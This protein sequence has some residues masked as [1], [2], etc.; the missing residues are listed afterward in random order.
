MASLSP[1]EVSELAI[2]AHEAFLEGQAGEDIR[3][4]FG[5]DHDSFREVLTK[6]FD[7]QATEVRGRPTEHVYVQYVIDQCRNIADLTK[8][9]GKFQTTSSHSAMVSAIRA[10]SDIQDK[11]LERGQ[12][13][14]IIAKEPEKSGALIAGIVIAD[15]SNPQLKQTVVRELANV[16][17][18]M[19]DTGDIDFM[20]IE[21]GPIHRGPSAPLPPIV[22]EVKVMAPTQARKKKKQRIRI[23]GD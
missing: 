15:L 16:R 6:M 21:V 4:G 9:I 12:E 17:K 1:E 5:L 2:V 19:L 14:G 23:V 13:F 11:V 7:A 8:L 18:M 10:R 3:E 20:D 22:A